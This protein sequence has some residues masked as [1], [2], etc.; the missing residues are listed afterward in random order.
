M[1][2]LRRFFSLYIT[3]SV[4]ILGL[5]AAA[6]AQLRRNDR[7]ISN[8]LRSLTTKMDNFR[9]GLSNELRRS[10]VSKFLVK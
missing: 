7:D 5:V 1:N 9:Y 2:R 4:V 10:S 6:N 8:T 3:V